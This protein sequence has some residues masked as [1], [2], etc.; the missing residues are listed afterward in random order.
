MPQAEPLK[1]VYVY[2]LT[3]SMG[4]KSTYGFTESAA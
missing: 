3:V 2:Y 4:Q 1:M